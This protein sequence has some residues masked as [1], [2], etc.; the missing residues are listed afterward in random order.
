MTYCLV[1]SALVVVLGSSLA[2][3]RTHKWREV[4]VTAIGSAAGLVLLWIATRPVP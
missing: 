2:R 3:H 4:Y 1:V